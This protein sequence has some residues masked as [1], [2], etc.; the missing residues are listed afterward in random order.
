ML[1]GFY[2]LIGQI[3]GSQ[4]L[5]AATGGNAIYGFP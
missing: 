5:A 4:L 3:K 1:G 2:A